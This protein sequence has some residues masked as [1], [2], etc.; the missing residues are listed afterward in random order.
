MSGGRPKGGG[1]RRGPGGGPGRGKGDRRDGGRGRPG[2]RGTTPQRRR[3]DGPPKGLGGDQV[4]GRQAVRELLL[5]GTRRTREVILAGDLDPAP[6]LDDIIDLADE[7]KVT[8]REVA[9]GRF[10]SMARTEAPQGVVAFAA[11]LE[12]HGLEA[13]LTSSGPA[14]RPPFLLLLDG[15]TDPGNLGAILRSAECAGVTGVVLPRHRAA[16]VTATAAKSAAGAIEHLRLATVSGLPKAMALLAKVGIWTVGLDIGGSD[17]IHDLTV[18]DG[19][20]ALVMGAEGAGLSRLVRERCDTVAHIPLQGVLASMNVSAAAAVALFEVAR[21][22][23][24]GA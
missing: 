5:A 2:Q 21:R 15:V 12:D 13:L 4:E 14:G 23:D 9:R 8:I 7:H 11:P 3:R 6:I 19:P 20:V 1:Q 24:A 18:A 16:R 22:R 10:E 17:T